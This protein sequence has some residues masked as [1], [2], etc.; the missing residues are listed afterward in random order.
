M[1]VIF[2][3]QMVDFCRP[4]HTLFRK[5]QYKITIHFYWGFID[6]LI[7]LLFLM[8]D[9]SLAIAYCTQSIISVANFKGFIF[10]GISEAVRRRLFMV[11]FLW[12]S[13]IA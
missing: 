7:I 8:S 9:L 5:V 1:M 12:H 11:I 4:S 10:S 13:L 3:A 6:N 2:C